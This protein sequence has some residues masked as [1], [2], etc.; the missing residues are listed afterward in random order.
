MSKIMVIDEDSA[1]RV[2]ISEWLTSEGHE[3]RSLPR[4]DSPGLGFT[5]PAPVDL[6][7]LDL[8]YQRTIGGA[9]THAVKAAQAAYPQAAVVGISAQLT[10]SLGAQADISRVLG[11]SCLL[12]KPCS[13]EE[14]VRAV[15]DALGR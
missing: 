13:R 7:V 14:L 1:M 3:V 10:R 4:H 9:A 15:A 11:V 12:A 2:L 8:P 6:I 5:H